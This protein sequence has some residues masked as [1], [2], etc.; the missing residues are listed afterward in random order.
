MTSNRNGWA[1]DTLGLGMFLWLI[2]Y[3][4]SLILFFTPFQVILGWILIAV[5]TPIT[6]AITWWWFRERSLPLVYYVEV[7][8]VWALIAIVLD[9]LFIVQLFQTPY[10]NLDVFIYYI[11]TFLIPVAVGFYRTS[12][13]R[14]PAI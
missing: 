11:L 12:G 1:K 9:Y 13:T 7:G 14:N 6:I 10:Y 4:T 3:L 8:A 5:F 2:G